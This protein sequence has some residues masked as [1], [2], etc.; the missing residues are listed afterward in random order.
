MEL[1]WAAGVTGAFSLLAI[2][3][4]RFAK[5]KKADHHVMQGILRSM[6]RSINRTENKIDKVS[7]KLSEHLDN[8]KK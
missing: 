1:V 2:V 6:H 5:D 4:T 8:H 7:D 3:V